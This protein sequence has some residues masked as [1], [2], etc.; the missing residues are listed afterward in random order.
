MEVNSHGELIV[1]GRIASG[2]GWQGLEAKSKIEGGF[3]LDKLPLLIMDFSTGMLSTLKKLG[4]GRRS[5]RC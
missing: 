1:A 5:W 3:G 4:R 2:R